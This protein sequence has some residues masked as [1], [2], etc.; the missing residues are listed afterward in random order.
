MVG[1]K[2]EK[3]VNTERCGGEEQEEEQQD[4]PDGPAVVLEELRLD[5]GDG[6]VWLTGGGEELVVGILGRLGG[7]ESASVTSSS[8]GSG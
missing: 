4:S 5:V 8:S 1:G 3:I 2:K 7:N 6:E